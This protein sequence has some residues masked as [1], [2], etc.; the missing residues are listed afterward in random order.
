[1]K[2]QT[3]GRD[4]YIPR[5]VKIGSGIQNL[6]RGNSQTHRKHGYLTSLL[7][8]FTNKETRLKKQ[9]IS[10]QRRTNMQAS[11]SSG[12][13]VVPLIPISD[14]RLHHKLENFT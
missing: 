7:L 6:I 4:F 14:T 2:T 9:G 11:L 5:F 13:L 12:S 10:N 1:M 8:M 3:D